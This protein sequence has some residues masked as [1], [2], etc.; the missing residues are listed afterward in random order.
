VRLRF[1][2]PLFSS[3]AKHPQSDPPSV[4]GFYKKGTKKGCSGSKGRSRKVSRGT[5]KEKAGLSPTKQQGTYPCL[6]CHS[7]PLGPRGRVASHLECGVVLSQTCRGGQHTRMHNHYSV[8][9]PLMHSSIRAIRESQLVLR[10]QWGRNGPA[11]SL[12]GVFAFILAR[13]SG[14]MPFSSK[15]ATQ[16]PGVS[17]R[18]AWAMHHLHRPAAA[19][20]PP[21]RYHQ[22]AA[23]G[24]RRS[25]A[26]ANQAGAQQG[27]SRRAAG[28]AQAAKQQRPPPLADSHAGVRIAQPAMV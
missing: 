7:A 14:S 17:G 8:W 9:V 2:F 18:A 21:P 24:R 11:L 6:T 16:R 26:T 23:T 28:G 1:L 4:E 25:A 3:T 12:H 13:F 19:A 22:Q 5:R 20:A 10:S 15:A 27:G